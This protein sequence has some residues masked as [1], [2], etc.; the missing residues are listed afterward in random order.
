MKKLISNI[1]MALMLASGLYG[2]TA[3]EDYLNKSPLSDIGEDEAFKNFRNFQG[4]TEELYNAIP[5]MS[6]HDYHNAFNFGDDDWRERTGG[7]EY[8]ADR[9]IDEGDYWSWTSG[10][11]AGTGWFGDGGNTSSNGRGDK[12]NLWGLAWKSIRKA[13]IGIANLDKL[14]GA[15]V[16]ERNLIEGQ[17]Y[18]FRAW[19]HFMLIQYWGG[20]PYIDSVLPADQPMRLSRLSYQECAEKIAADFTHAAELLPVNWDDTTVGKQTLGQNNLRCNKI[21]ALAYL[22]KNLLWAG[23]PLMNSV[24][25]GTATY[26]TDYCKRAAD[27]FAQALT[28]TESTGRYKLAPFS[29]YS[30]LFYTHNQNGKI[31]GLQEA[32]FMEN[33]AES[34]NRWRWNMVTN[35]RPMCIITG[36]IKVYPSAGYTHWYGMKNGYPINN[37]SQADSESGYDP[38]HPWKDRDPRFYNDIVYDGVKCTLTPRTATVDNKLM[39]VQYAGLAN[40]GAYRLSNGARGAIT[41]YMCTKLVPPLDNDWDGYKENN[42]VV[43]C[44]MRLADVYLMY[45]EATVMGYGTPQS[46]ASGYSLSALDAV[47]KI[48]ER[49]GVATVLDKFT[50][51]AESFM[52]ELRRERAVELAFEGHRFVDLRRWML[53]LEKPYTLKTADEFDRAV[54]N[55]DYTKPEEARVLNLR[56]VVLFERQFGQ[57]HYWFP[58]KSD[59]VNMY[60]E[61][62]QNPGW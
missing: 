3:C 45:A 52:S 1:T 27:A 36:G 25:G 35:Y 17:L 28:L 55:M 12:K 47:N 46:K 57:K 8:Y 44:F 22:G 48:R 51:S 11:N 60:P 13:N 10:S 14:T 38:E 58:L 56:E 2:L 40:N 41:G 9:R 15:T 43:L 16:E 61:F 54:E 23:S 29:Q 53:L 20:L 59:D 33:L 37:I 26:N 39:D 6:A 18:F 42:V 34:T 30:E 49:A 19:Y 31:P 24:S 7:Y 5:L 50:G 21:M 32:I 4:F 62:E